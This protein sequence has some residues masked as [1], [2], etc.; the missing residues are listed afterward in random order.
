MIDAE[1]RSEER[2]SR[3]SIAYEKNEEKELVNSTINKIIAKYTIQPE[4]IHTTEISNAREVV[5]VEYH[6]DLDRE[7]GA[8]FEEIITALNI[9]ECD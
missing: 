6:D 7:S 9:K 8:I 1:V 4:E 2:F 5:V 3:L